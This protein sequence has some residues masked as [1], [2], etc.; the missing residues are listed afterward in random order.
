MTIEE[1]NRE[2]QI[3]E[4]IIFAAWEANQIDRE[5]LEAEIDALGDW[6]VAATL[7]YVEDMDVGRASRRDSSD[8]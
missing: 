6:Y 3:K 2:F 8:E 1:I 4:Q 5:E 7:A